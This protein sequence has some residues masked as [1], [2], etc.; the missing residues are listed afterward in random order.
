MKAI[1][2]LDDIIYIELR[3]FEGIYLCMDYLDFRWFFIYVVGRV[4]GCIYFIYT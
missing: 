1:W 4:L 3:N 2:I